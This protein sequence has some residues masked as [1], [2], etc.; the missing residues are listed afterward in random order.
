LGGRREER[1]GRRG[2]LRRG[3]EGGE[4]WGERIMTSVGTGARLWTVA[5]DASAVAVAVIEPC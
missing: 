4:E 1:R 5:T 2:W 3:G